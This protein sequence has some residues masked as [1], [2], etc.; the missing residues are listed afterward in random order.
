[1]TRWFGPS[2]YQPDPDPDRE[3]GVPT[4]G[5]NDRG[6]NSADTVVCGKSGDMDDVPGV[7]VV[8][9]RQAVDVMKSVRVG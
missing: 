5:S 1:V 7:E 9:P 2:R 3:V 6:N 8:L 4:V